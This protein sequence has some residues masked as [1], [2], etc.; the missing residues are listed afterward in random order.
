M[1]MKYIEKDA[2]ASPI[3]EA[4]L[5]I[6]PTRTTEAESL[7]AEQIRPESRSPSCA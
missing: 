7:Y 4:S 5:K 6:A 2:V 1:Q 3:I